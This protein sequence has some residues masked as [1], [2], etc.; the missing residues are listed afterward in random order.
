MKLY[1]LDGSL[2]LLSSFFAHE[3]RI[4]QSC[5]T[6]IHLLTC[7]EDSSIRLWSH[8]STGEILRCFSV[9]RC[10]SA[11]CMDILRDENNDKP[12]VIVS[13][14]SDGA[15]RRYHLD[16][17]PIDSHETI[18][19][20]QTI[21]NDYP[22]N[23]VFFNSLLMIVQMNSGQLWRVDQDQQSIFYDGRETLKNGY[24]K[25]SVAN[26]LLAVGSLNG[27]VFIF[28]RNG[29]MKNDFQIERNGNRKILQI[30]W[31]NET[32]LTKLLVC[33]P[34]GIMVKGENLSFKE[35]KERSRGSFSFLE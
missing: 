27:S 13:G 15:V 14:W 28:D 4:W 18:S 7:G 10:K 22:R 20:N 1:H 30:L 6:S 17:V 25:M 16:D 29:T 9:H 24:A 12:L 34:D 2:Q 5:T 33:I 32:S 23:V 8:K 35:E 26:E 31:L 11:W 19:F 3:A 21:D